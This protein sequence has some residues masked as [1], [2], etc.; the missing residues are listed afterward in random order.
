MREKRQIMITFCQTGQTDQT[1]FIIY[2]GKGST[3]ISQL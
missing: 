1:Q 3:T 2:T